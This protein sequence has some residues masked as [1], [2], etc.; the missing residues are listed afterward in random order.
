M[1]APDS[2]TGA[3]LPSTVHQTSQ[4]DSPI[5][6]P[7]VPITVPPDTVGYLRAKGDPL[8]RTP[9]VRISSKTSP[10]IPRV[11]IIAP[12]SCPVP[13]PIKCEEDLAGD[14][15]RVLLTRER[16]ERER[17]GLDL[18]RISDACCNQSDSGSSGSGDDC[19]ADETDESALSGTE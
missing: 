17:H 9:A 15:I 19:W 7:T 18:L 3:I 11:P 14:R 2:A 12:P 8:V 6:P 10:K 16:D 5:C 4:P 13:L 1:D